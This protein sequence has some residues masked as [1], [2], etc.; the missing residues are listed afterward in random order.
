ME[1]NSSM[2]LEVFDEQMF[3]SFTYRLLV[4]RIHNG[5]NIKNRGNKQMNYNFQEF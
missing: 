5:I 2:P 3:C 1:Y 4:L